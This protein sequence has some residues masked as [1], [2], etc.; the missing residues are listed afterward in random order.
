MKEDLNMSGQDYNLLQ[1]MFTV[2]KYRIAKE[3]SLGTWLTGHF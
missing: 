3:S 2:G 1:T